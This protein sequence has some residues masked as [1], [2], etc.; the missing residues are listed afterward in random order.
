M[1]PLTPGIGISPPAVSC[2]VVRQ[3]A[4]PQTTLTPQ[5]TKSR[6]V[7]RLALVG[8]VCSLLVA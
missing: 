3:I 4:L 7:A 1:S 6:K 2:C 8:L 5:E